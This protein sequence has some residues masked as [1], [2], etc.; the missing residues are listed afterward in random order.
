MIRR[1]PHALVSH[2]TL[3]SADQNDLCAPLLHSP[4]SL[5][6]VRA[7][8]R[9][10]GA[11]TP[12]A[13]NTATP[14]EFSDS[15]DARNQGVAPA[16][17]ATQRES[18]AARRLQSLPHKPHSEFCLGAP[19]TRN[20]VVERA[21]VPSGPSCARTGLP[22]LPPRITCSA[23]RSPSPLHPILLIPASADRPAPS[24]R[25]ERAC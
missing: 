8:R 18:P 15:P 17:R 12:R 19:D 9:E 23:R 21:G 7:R 1:M 25:T 10:S 16:G 24:C 14:S 5:G 4:P 2:S 6:R 22:H 11:C 13:N 3:V 20:G